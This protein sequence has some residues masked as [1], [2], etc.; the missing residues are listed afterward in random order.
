M[1]RR[2][3]DDVVTARMVELRNL[4]RLHA[5]DRKQIAELKAELATVKAENMQLKQVVATLQ[6]QMAELQAM[7]FGKKKRPPMGGTPIAPPAKQPRSPDS[8]RRPLPPAHAVTTEMALPLPA[9]CTCGGSFD[10]TSITTHERY[11]EDMPLP[12]LT[13]DYQAHLVTKYVIERGVCLACGK[14]A[15]GGGK[16]LGGAQVALGPNVRLLVC[17][18]IAVVGMSYS[19]TSGLL[20]AL[21]GLAVTDGELANMLRTQHIAWTPSYNQLQADIRAAP[22]VH[23]DETPWPIQD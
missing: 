12:G 9:A 18:L 23:A 10:S 2:L 13:P 22:V 16:D 7:V 21:Y 14:A 5:H 6:I 20:L 1:A 11:E 19:Q 3:S 8:Y 17:H 4:R 15:T